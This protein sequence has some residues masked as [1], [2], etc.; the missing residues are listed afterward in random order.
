MG[1]IVEGIVKSPEMLPQSRIGIEVKGRSYLPCDP[2]NRYVLA[3][4]FIVS[5]LE[6]MHGGNL[7]CLKCAK[8]PKMPKVGS[9]AKSAPD[10]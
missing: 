4:K 8:L 10:A 5:V 1:N 3:V 9:S 7:E 6:V 2:G